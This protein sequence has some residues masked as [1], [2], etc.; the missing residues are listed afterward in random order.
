MWT[1]RLGHRDLRQTA[2][3]RRYPVHPETSTSCQGC[4][5]RPPKHCLAFETTDEG[6]YVLWLCEVCDQEATTD[7][8]Q[9]PLWGTDHGLGYHLAA[10]AKRSLLMV[11]AAYL[12]TAWQASAAWGTCTPCLTVG[13]LW[14]CP[15]SFRDFACSTS[16]GKWPPHCAPCYLATVERHRTA[17]MRD[18]AALVSPSATLCH[19][20]PLPRDIVLVIWQTMGRLID[21]WDII[22]RDV[23]RQAS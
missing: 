14:G 15:T 23:A 7:L 10:L 13:G 22:C 5:I 21:L 16:F 12:E 9:R 20:L 4:F 11:D 19:L 3:I 2:K 8:A 6:G 1:L 18:E 17:L